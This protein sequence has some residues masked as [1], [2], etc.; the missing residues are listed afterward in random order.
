MRAKSVFAQPPTKPSSLHIKVYHLRWKYRF[1]PDRELARKLG[2]SLDDFLRLSDELRGMHDIWKY[3]L[4]CEI[5]SI[6]YEPND[7]Q[8]LCMKCGR[9]YDDHDPTYPIVF[10]VGS[11][12]AL[13][14]GKNLGTKYSFN[15]LYRILGYGGVSGTLRYLKANLYLSADRNT[16]EGKAEAIVLQDLENCRALLAKVLRPV[17]LQNNPDDILIADI[18]GNELEKLVR[19]YHRVVP[20]GKSMSNQLVHL[21]VLQI[22]KSAAETRSPRFQKVFEEFNREFQ[23]RGIEPPRFR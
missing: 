14:A 20:L 8:H 9:V 21:Y 11:H 17:L 6:V 18:L 2:L 3:C 12:I 1:P 10:G 22:L 13:N 5:P 19:K 16:P 15:D 23:K 7:V 4:D